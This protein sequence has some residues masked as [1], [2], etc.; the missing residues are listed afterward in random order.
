MIGKLILLNKKCKSDDIQLQLCAVAPSILLTGLEF[1]VIR[2]APVRSWE[3]PARHRI[4]VTA[5]SPICA[6]SAKL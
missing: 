5:V 1:L 2:L 6:E 4:V 3:P